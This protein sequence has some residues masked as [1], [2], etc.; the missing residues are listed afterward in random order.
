MQILRNGIAFESSIQRTRVPLDPN[1]PVLFKEQS[2]TDVIFV[3]CGVFCHAAE[4]VVHFS[5]TTVARYDI[6]AD[7]RSILQYGFAGKSIRVSTARVR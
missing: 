4:Y 6:L 5:V 3:G 7:D 1:V 2:E